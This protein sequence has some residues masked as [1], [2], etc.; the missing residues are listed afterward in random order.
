METVI[1]NHELIEAGATSGVGF[2]HKQLEALGVDFPLIKGW[3]RAL[4]GKKITKIDYERFLAL[5]RQVVKQERIRKDNIL[6]RFCLCGNMK[7]VNNLFCRC[8]KSRRGPNKL[9]FDLALF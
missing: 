3:K 8:C 6:N 4:I 7:S 5:N 9:Q 2:C 1:L